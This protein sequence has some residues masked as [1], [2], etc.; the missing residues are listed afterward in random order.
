[1]QVS[2][3]NV[4]WIM[5]ELLSTA[6]RS[7]FPTPGQGLQAQVSTDSRQLL[8]I[9]AADWPMAEGQWLVWELRRTGIRIPQL[10]WRSL[11]HQ[12]DCQVLA[13][14]PWSAPTGPL[15]ESLMKGLF[16]KVWAEKYIPQSHSFSSLSSPTGA[17][18]LRFGG[19]A[20]DVAWESEKVPRSARVSELHI[21]QLTHC[22]SVFADVL[23]FGFFSFQS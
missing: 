2:F 22:I 10:E 13:G 4:G 18:H 12:D 8:Y 19:I 6:F 15:E 11:P 21:Q 17:P 3:S 14:R 20:E 1:M 9:S 5:S 16:M 23:F 7:Q